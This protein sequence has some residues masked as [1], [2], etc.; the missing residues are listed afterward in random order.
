MTDNRKRAEE[1]IANELDDNM[2]AGLKNM[3]RNL[4]EKSLDEAEARGFER[5]IEEAANLCLKSSVDWKISATPTNQEG[6]YAAEAQRLS[7][8]I[9]A[10]KKDGGK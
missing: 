9:R 10:L 3:L 8:F 1:I 7:G 2:G 5:G 4:V 6:R